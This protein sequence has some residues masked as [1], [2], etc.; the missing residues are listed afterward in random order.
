VHELSLAERMLQMQAAEDAARGSR[1]VV[2][3]EVAWQTDT[4][5]ALLVPDLEKIATSVAKDRRVDD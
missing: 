5:V 3:H 4:R 2:L 1:D